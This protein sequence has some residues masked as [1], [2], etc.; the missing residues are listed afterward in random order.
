M[1]HWKRRTLWIIRSGG[2]EV[3]YLDLAD[4]DDHLL[5]GN[6]IIHPSHQR[7]GLGTA[8]LLELLD[9]LDNKPARLQ[10]FR[11]NPARSLYERLGFRVIATTA[12]HHRMERS[13]DHVPGDRHT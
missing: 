1:D 8:V 13:A 11:D 2:T 7:R 5:I 3:G 4:E 12:H 6:I 9:K 10:V